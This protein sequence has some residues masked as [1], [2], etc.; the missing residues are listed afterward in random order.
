MLDDLML[1]EMGHL[2]FAGTIS[3]AKAYFSSIGYSNPDQINAADYYLEIVQHAPASG[4]T[5]KDLFSKSEYCTIYS[6]V[7]ADIIAQ[8]CQLKPVEVPSVLS[9]FSTMFAHFTKYNIQER[10]IYVHRLIALIV[11]A[12]FMGTLFLQL[13]PTTNELGSYVGAMFSTAISLVLTA[14]SSTYI[15]ARNRREAVERIANGIY[16]PGTFVA[17]QFL[18]SAI[19]S[20]IVSF[21]FV[22]IFHWLVDLCPDGDCFVYDIFIS[23]GHLMMMEAIIHI[24]VEVLKNDFLATSASM[25]WIGTNMLFAGFFRSVDQVPPAIS[26][27]MYWVPMRVSER[28]KLYV[29]LLLP[30]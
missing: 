29:L 4:E 8:N 12:I 24:L 1:L 3:D 19:F 30:L 14:V 7:L 21:I 9:R 20:W 6:N 5:W 22:C 10:G 2:V 13:E 28:D 11:I 23:W 26:W 18:S 16:T 15:Y 25:I 27:M 17:A